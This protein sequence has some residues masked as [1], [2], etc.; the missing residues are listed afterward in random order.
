MK[1]GVKEDKKMVYSLRVQG[2]DTSPT[3]LPADF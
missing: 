3:A 2:F 1:D